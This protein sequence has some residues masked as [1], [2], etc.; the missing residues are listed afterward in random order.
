VNDHFDTLPNNQLDFK[1]AAITDPL[2]VTVNMRI[3]PRSVIIQPGNTAV[4]FT[5]AKGVVKFNV[6]GVDVYSIVEIK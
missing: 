3:K 5:Y 4:P 1:M 6:P 2:A